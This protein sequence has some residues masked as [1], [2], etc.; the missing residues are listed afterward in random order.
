VVGDRRDHLVAALGG[1]VRSHDI[2]VESGCHSLLEG[3]G[4]T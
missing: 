4:P 2:G 3:T 1:G